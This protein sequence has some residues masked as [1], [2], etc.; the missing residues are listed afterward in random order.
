MIGKPGGGAGIVV[1]I[2]GIKYRKVEFVVDQVVKR[3]FE[4]AGEDL[5]VKGNGDE[6][7][8]R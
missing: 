4:R 1:A 2:T 6:L 8:W 3:I 7:P 5:L